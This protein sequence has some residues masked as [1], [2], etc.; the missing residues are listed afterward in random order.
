MQLSSKLLLEFE[1]EIIESYVKIKIQAGLKE[2]K[3]TTN[4]ARGIF[5]LGLVFVLLGA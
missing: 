5:F 2:T 4:L 1:N 3:V